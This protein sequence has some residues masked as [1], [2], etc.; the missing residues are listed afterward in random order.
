V[1]KPLRWTLGER[2]DF[3]TCSLG[4]GLGSR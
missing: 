1:I 3:V 2:N 4:Q